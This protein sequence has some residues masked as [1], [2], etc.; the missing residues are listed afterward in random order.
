MRHTT[1]CALHTKSHLSCKLEDIFG[2]TTHRPSPRLLHPARHDRGGA[3]LRAHVGRRALLVEV[4]PGVQP[5][6][7]WPAAG[8]RHHGGD[9]GVQ[10]GGGDA[11]A[12]IQH[13]RPAAMRAHGGV[14]KEASKCMFEF[15]PFRLGKGLLQQERESAENRTKACVPGSRLPRI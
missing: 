11:R 5:G 3:Q 15:Q 14:C 8:V 4:R 12:G 9:E 10:R 2:E 6:V 7:Q 1:G 13:W